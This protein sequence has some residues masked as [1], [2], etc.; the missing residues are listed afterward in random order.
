MEQPEPVFFYEREFYPFSNF[1]SFMVMYEGTLWATSE[2][3]YQASKFTEPSLIQEIK[4]ARSSHDAF[5]LSRKYAHLEKSN[6]KEIRVRVMEEIVREKLVQHPVIQKKL[7]ETGSREIL[8]DSP[9]DSFWGLGP[10]K[11]GE[12]QLGKI[13]M[14][15]RDGLL[16]KSR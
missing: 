9:I 4:E 3:A 2:H 15:L 10:N 14:K 5:Q 6:W 11:D 13:W 1:S 8:E 16:K 7:E 12:N